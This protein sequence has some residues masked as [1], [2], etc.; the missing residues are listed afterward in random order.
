MPL[1]ALI[2]LLLLFLAFPASAQPQCGYARAVQFPVDPNVFMLAQDFGAA[3]PRHQGRFHTGEDWTLP[4][5]AALGQIV[6]APADGRVTFSSPNAWGS[7]GGVLI[8]EHTF[9][10][11]SVAYS[12]FGHLTEADGITF[13]PALSC[14]RMG[15]PLATIADVRPA[16]HVHIEIRTSGGAIPGA[17]YSWDEPQSADLRRPTK[18]LINQALQLGDSYRWRIDLADEAGPFGAPVLLDDLSLI[19]L[20]GGRVN[21]ITDDGRLLWRTLLESPAAGLFPRD[22]GAWVLFTDGRWQAVLRD[23]S[24]GEA[25]ET[26][27]PL[28]RVLLALPDRLIA[29]TAD[30]RIAAF[31]AAGLPLWQSA[32]AL[33]AVTAAAAEPV[34]GRLALMARD[35]QGGG[36]LL[37]LNVDGGTIDAAQL[38][39]P[40]PIQFAPS[41]WLWTYTRGGLWGVDEGGAWTLMDA[42]AAPG[43]AS[44]ALAFA[45][46]GARYQ[47]DGQTLIAFGPDGAPRWQTSPGHV[48]GQNMLMAESD[49]LLLVSSGGEL[50]TWR[51]SDGAECGRARLWAG[52]S[53]WANLGVDG[54]LRVAIA[55]QIAA[56]DWADLT[57]ACG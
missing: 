46:D 41:G 48:A 27:V 4:G 8:L 2:C 57:Q 17:G 3:S 36:S 45:G 43:G 9:P 54:L 33:P 42:A 10:D 11:G 32:E 26:G 20:D 56:L 19:Y 21:R 23:G 7:D 49:R 16:P 22:D 38:A 6:Y 37:L 53:A 14:V 15:E 40:A 25:N 50:V 47:F 31:D 28:A 44:A 34:S 1:V 51:R 18:F 12:M 35:V 30:G 52:P 29:Q 55:D 39:E 5:G 24:L 13:P